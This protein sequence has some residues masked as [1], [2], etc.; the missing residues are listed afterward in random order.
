MVGGLMILIRLSLWKPAYSP[1][2][3]ILEL[4]TVMLQ[5]SKW[6]GLQ[7]CGLSY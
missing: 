5:Q 1:Y 3:I 7:R 4:V 6:R 2:K